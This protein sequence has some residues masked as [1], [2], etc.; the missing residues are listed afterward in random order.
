MKEHQEAQDRSALILEAYEGLERED[1][2]VLQGLL[3]LQ[4]GTWEQAVGFA[5]CKLV[6]E[7][8]ALRRR[9]EN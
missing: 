2:G 8:R 1:P 5:L 3:A 4:N 9:L 7:N 6:G